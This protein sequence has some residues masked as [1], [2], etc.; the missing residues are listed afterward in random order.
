MRLNV[1][2]KPLKAGEL[3]GSRDTGEGVVICSALSNISYKS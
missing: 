2:R 3:T 1:M